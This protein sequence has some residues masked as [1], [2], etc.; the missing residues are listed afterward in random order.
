[1]RKKR[2]FRIDRLTIL[3]LSAFVF[4]PLEGWAFEIKSSFSESQDSSEEPAPSEEPASSQEE[5]ES[6]ASSPEG[7]FTTLSFHKPALGTQSQ[8]ASSDTA[9]TAASSDEKKKFKLGQMSSSAS[10]SAS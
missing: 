1:M 5:T 3:L 9:S 10:S 8:T 4:L 2:R 6:Q 7:N